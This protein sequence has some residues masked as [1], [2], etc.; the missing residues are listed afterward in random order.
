MGKASRKQVARRRHVQKANRAANKARPPVVPSPT[1]RVPQEK[2]R[3]RN[4]FFSTLFK[5]LF[6]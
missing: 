6:A 2:P 1:I 3:G 4:G 5:G